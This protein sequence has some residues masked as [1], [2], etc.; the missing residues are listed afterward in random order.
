MNE[1]QN[2]SRPQ[3]VSF[4]GKINLVFTDSHLEEVSNDLS[5][6]KELGFDTETKPSFRR[7]EVYQVALVQLATESDAYLIRLHSIKK[8][9]P[10]KKI[11]ENRNILKVGLALRHDLKQLQKLFAFS[12]ENFVDLQEVAKSKGLKNFGLKG[13]T[14]EVLQMSLTKGPKL[15]N[16]E[17]HTLSEQQLT[18]AATDAWIGLQIYKKLKAGDQP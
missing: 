3:F 16:W 12:A 2:L 13:L 4:Q 1:S 5:V 8:F 18:Y 14:D 6:A 9:D 15:T 7:G 10:L 17:A 11:F